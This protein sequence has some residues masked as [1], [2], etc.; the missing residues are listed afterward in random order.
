MSQIS[1]G[2]YI[3]NRLKEINIDTIFGVPGDFNM[4]LLDLIEDDVELTWGNN[5]N[6][7]NSAYAA[8]GYARVCGAGAV[9]TAFGVGELSAI[10]GIAGS[11]SEM[12]PVIHIVGTPRT[13]TQEKGSLM[14]HSLGNG[15]FRVFEK[16]SAMVTIASAS[17]T[18]AN[19]ISEIDRV[20][21]TAVIEKRPGY[22][23]LPFDL[24]NTMVEL[25]SLFPLAVSPPKSPEQVKNIATKEILRVIQ[26]SQNPA[27]IVDGCILRHRLTDEANE[28]VKVAGFPTFSAPMGKGAIDESLP[29]Y[30]GVYAGA[31]SFKEVSEEIKNADLLIEIGSIK[32]D[33]NTGNFTYGL[34]NIKTIS[35]NGSNTIIFH[36]EYSGVRMQDVLPLL[37]AALSESKSSL[38]YKPRARSVPIDNGTV[39]ITHNYLWNKVPEYIA[40]NA[41]IVSETGTSEFGVFNMESPKGATFIGQI[42]W[43]S[44]GY[45]VGAAVGAAMA[46]RGRK[47]YLF[48]GD[49]SFQLTVQEISVFIRQGLT[50]V[51]F[52]L[53]NDGYLMEK[54]IHGPER[55]YNNF[56][57]WKYSQTLDYFGGNLEV[58]KTEGKNPSPIGI[59]AKV[60]TRQEFENAMEKVNEEPDKIHFLEVIMPAF[61]SPREL[62]LLCDLSENR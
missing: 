33:F 4:P 26:K 61:D 31:I 55:S 60:S 30:R 24:I 48:V 17:L 18:L 43:G 23:S 15:D 52:L 19:A 54:L 28:F 2:Q 1:I 29:N 27:I 11:Y 34:E 3:L 58:N 44:I 57:M 59:E 37:T 46:D 56:Q 42:L 51:I 10:N 50:P 47:V 25:P 20:I 9:V 22:I 41:I 5:A 53:N 13:T 12:L 49:G 35:L 32:S 16:M 21:Q 39:E 7:L 38:D 6:E 14:H 62:L 8:D 40:E 36:A 45:S